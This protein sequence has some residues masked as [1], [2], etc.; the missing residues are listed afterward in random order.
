MMRSW[1]ESLPQIEE[2]RSL[3]ISIALD[4]FGTGYSTLS[5]LHLLPVDYIKIDR[6]FTWRLNDQ[7]G[8]GLILIQAITDLVHRFGFEV[9]A[10]GVETA[11]QLSDLKSIGCDI[12]QGYLLGRP[13]SVER[14]RGLLESEQGHLRGN[15]SADLQALVRV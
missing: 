11:Q 6:S 2:L 13:M 9:V 14:V 3:G 5:A 15:S 7:S 8:D 10:E 12:F 1:K 4:D